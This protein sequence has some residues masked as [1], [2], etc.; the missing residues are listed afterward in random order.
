M[1][2]TIVVLIVVFA[3]AFSVWRL[4]PAKRRLQALQSLD[5]WAARHP[6]LA[7]FRERSI[8]PRI[9]KAAGPGCAGCAANVGVRPHHPK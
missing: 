9:L 3:A 6:S 5:A 1:Q 7:N 8:R 4:M 2:E